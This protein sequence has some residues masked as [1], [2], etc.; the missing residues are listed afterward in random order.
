[1]IIQNDGTAHW[2]LKADASPATARIFAFRDLPAYEAGMRGFLES[3]FGRIGA[4]VI[5]GNP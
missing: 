2:S 1:V 5:H 3:Q 4:S